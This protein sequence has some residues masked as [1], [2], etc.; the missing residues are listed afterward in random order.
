MC[1]IQDAGV[2]PQNI[3]IFFLEA[4]VRRWMMWSEDGKM[5]R[6]GVYRGHPGRLLF[7]RLALCVQLAVPNKRL[8]KMGVILLFAAMSAFEP[9]KHLL[10]PSLPNLPFLTMRNTPRRS[11]NMRKMAQQKK[12]HIRLGCKVKCVFARIFSCCSR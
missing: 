2:P 7:H 9:R 5:A 11:S 6:R 4:S 12:G 8:V 3:C 1:L 10:S